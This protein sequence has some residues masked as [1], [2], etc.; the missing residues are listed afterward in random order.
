MLSFLMLSLPDTPLHPCPRFIKRSD[1][2]GDF[3]PGI[4]ARPGQAYAKTKKLKISQH[5]LP[6]LDHDPRDVKAAM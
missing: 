6:S 2:H 1:P 4:P 5:S 3:H